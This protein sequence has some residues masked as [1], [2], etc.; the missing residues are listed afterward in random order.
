[1]KNF[2]LLL[3]FIFSISTLNAAESESIVDKTKST[4]SNAKDSISS[5]LSEIDTSSMSKQFYN[6]VKSAVSALAAGL[7]TGVEHVVF[8]LIK[9][10]VVYSVVNILLYVILTIIIIVG[11]NFTRKTYNNHLTKCGWDGKSSAYSIDVEDSSL[12]ILSVLLSVILMVITICSVIFI[13]DSFTDTV[14]GF[15]NPE[16][17]AYKEILEYIKK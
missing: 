8:V 7:K 12:G 14:T 4:I 1:M 11:V 6:D 3:C 17:G 13:C 9:Q 5:T 15:V 10:Q 16:Y 2:I